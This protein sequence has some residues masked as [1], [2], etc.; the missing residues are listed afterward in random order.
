M[1][2]ANFLRRN[3]VIVVSLPALF[4]IHVGWY[5]LQFNDQFVP[6]KDRK[7]RLLGVNLKSKPEQNTSQEEKVAKD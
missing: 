1:S 3:I 5:K 2:L 6:E 4:A 7:L